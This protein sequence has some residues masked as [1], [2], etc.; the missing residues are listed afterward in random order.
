[1]SISVGSMPRTPSIV[2]SSTGKKQKN[3]M[4]ATFCTLPIE[5]SRMIEIGSSAGGGIARQY[6][7]CG[8]ASDAVPSRERPSGM[9]SAMPSDDAR[10][11]SRAPM[12]S[13]LGTTCS[14]NCENSQM[15]WNSTRIVDSRGKNCESACTVH[16]LPGGEE[17]DRHG[18]LGADLRARVYA[19]GSRRL[20]RCEG[21]QR[22]TRRSSALDSEV[23]RD[24]EEARSRARRRRARR[25]GRTTTRS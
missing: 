4:K 24:A 1:M 8:I 12:R 3:A 25:S 13:R 22:S 20:P 2:F 23:D 7:M 14:S 19:R 5:C 16:D 15:S 9:P 18:D 10:C 17:R 11:R 21:C 6:S